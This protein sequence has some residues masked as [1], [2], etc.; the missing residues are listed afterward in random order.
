[1]KT[2]SATHLASKV[3]SLEQRLADAEQLIDAIK[4]GEVDAFAIVNN[5][6]SEVYTLQSGDYAYRVLVERFGEGALNLTEDGLIV[7][8][9]CYFF[10]LLGLPY[11]KVVGTYIFEY[12]ADDSKSTF[13]SLFNT[14]PEGNTK[15]EINLAVDGT[16]IPV[17]ISLTSLQPHLPT[18]GMIVTDL[19]EKKSNEKIITGYQG[20]LEEKNRLLSNKNKQLE[21][22]I[23][24]EFSENFS[25]YKTGKVFFDSLTL[26]LAAKTMMDYVFIGE[27]IGNGGDNPQIRTI[28]LTAFGKPAENI[29]YPLPHGPCEQVIMGTLYSYPK[30]CQH[31]FPQNQTIKQFNVEGYIGYPLFD[32]ERNPIGLIAV[33]HTKAIEDVAYTESLLKIAAKRTEMEMER[34][35]NEKMLEAKNIELEN[36]N[37]ELASFSYIASH[38]LQEPLRKIQ[39]FTS[40]I[41]DKENHKLSESGKDYFERISD[42]ASRMQKLIE[43]LLNYSRTNTTEITLEATDL[44]FVLEDVKKDLQELIRRKKAVIHADHLPTLNIVSLQ[45]H[46]LFS[47]IISNAIKYSKPNVPPYIKITTSVVPASEVKDEAPLSKSKYWKISITDNGIGFDQQYE[48][49]VFELFQRLHGKKEFEG[50]GIGLA[51]CKKI[52]QNHKGII[53][54]I[55]TPGVGATFNIYLPVEDNANTS[56]GSTEDFK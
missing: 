2:E 5:D 12:I 26:S 43:A 45:F 41:L 6:K 10:N 49:K 46:Q 29:E 15:G 36:Q 1:M 24:D 25:A 22:Q 53:N 11:E 34:I 50:T 27:L 8:S 30:A 54:A 35:R 52:M 37:A 28:S 3:E 20:E 32:T 21:Q 23:L 4:A 7:Y 48:P 56:S 18:I 42:A 16:T 9:N 19:T 33:M 40:R 13:E 31:K 51:I 47:N 39:A 38:D 17:L 14:V 55:G 44:N